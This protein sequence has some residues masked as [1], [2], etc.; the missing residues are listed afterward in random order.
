MQKRGQVTIFVIVGILLLFTII[1]I[2]WLVRIAEQDRLDAQAQEAVDAFIQTTA[3][4]HYITSCLDKVASEGLHVLT[5]QG[6]VIYDYQGGLTSTQTDAG[7]LFEVGYQYYPYRQIFFENGQLVSYTYNISYA[8]RPYV[9]CP[10]FV[11]LPTNLTD[12]A[13]SYYPVAKT[14]FSDYTGRFNSYFFANPPGCGLL[15]RQTT[16]SGFLGKNNLPSLCS[17]DGVNLG[18]GVCH[19]R[20]G[21]DTVAEQNAMERQLERYI[22]TQ[23]P[24]CVNISMYELYSGSNVT[25][26]DAPNITLLFQKPRGVLVQA[27]YPFLVSIQGKEPILK[28]ALFQKTLPVAMNNFFNY[29]FMYIKQ[30][31][32][33]PFFSI[34]ADWHNITKNSFYLPYY[35]VRIH[36]STYECNDS[37]ISYCTDKVLTVTDTSSELLGKPLTFQFAIAQRKPV[38]NYLHD[39]SQSAVINSKQIN[40]QYQIND[41]ISLPVT[42]MDPDGDAIEVNVSGWKETFDDYLDVVA[43]NTEPGGCT[44]EN[45]WAHMRKKPLLAD[46]IRWTESGIFLT[47]S[48]RMEYKTND[49]DLGLH[50]VTIIVT[51]EYGLQDFQIVRILVFDLPKAVLNAYNLFTDINDSFASVEDP[52]VLDGSASSPSILAG[53][54]LTD[55]Q[56]EDLTEDVL[57]VIQESTLQLPVP[58][59]ITIANITHVWFNR[60]RLSSSMPAEE[61][62]ITLIVKQGDIA[63]SNPDTELITVTQCLPHGYTGYDTP[64]ATFSRDDFE[65][66]PY[67][68]SS[69]PDSYAA[70]HVCCEPSLLFSSS[71]ANP[72]QLKGGT[73]APTSVACYEDTFRTTYP[74]FSYS[75]L[76]KAVVDTSDGLVLPATKENYETIF[77]TNAYRAHAY[78]GQTFYHTPDAINFKTNN[79]LN[80]IWQVSYRQSCSGQRGNICGGKLSN[81]WFRTNCP[82]TFSAP[83][84]FARC[85]GPN[86]VGF[87]IQDTLLTCTSYTGTTFEQQV[88]DS[89]SSESGLQE[90]F[91]EVYSPEEFT[92]IM[93]GHCA[94]PTLANLQP[95]G[96]MTVAVS[97]GAFSCMGTCD[98]G[99]CGFTDLTLCSC[100]KDTVC[101]AF[102]ADDFIAVDGTVLAH[103]CLGSGEQAVACTRSCLPSPSTT[104]ASCECRGGTYF[105]GNCCEFGSEAVFIGP[106]QGCFQGAV[107]DPDTIQ[108]TSQGSTLFCGGQFYVCGSSSG[109]TNP[110]VT[111]IT[112]GF[113][114]TL[115]GR[116]CMSVGP[117]WV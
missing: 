44:L 107:F 100:D 61:H 101:D 54:T 21:F 103:R 23:L 99:D 94:G 8:I 57:H 37:T 7:N 91:E 12:E 59:G 33:D 4:N 65:S 110:L 66:L 87:N 115:C 113:G 76:N 82:D 85:H 31:V 28:Q 45:H 93:A 49:T 60:S 90:R 3:L 97:V 41:T 20:F 38:L 13:T 2:T 69:S 79:Q 50:N 95:T 74:F 114:T 108:S 1:I 9:D 15:S 55:Y 98:G 83:N 53:G 104:E 24:T 111:F 52:Y 14:F 70:S 81:T 117:S 84:Q 106:D 51:D 26:I 47:P 72:P 22:Q 19:S 105:G 96:Y 112:P 71:A 75:L 80:D 73:Y 39:S 30:A 77:G 67:P 10:S 102:T 56:F 89:I 58:E 35:D 88:Y 16:W 17:Y 18:K 62:E 27:E 109:Y 36:H 11:Y 86:F 116:T 34:T 40:Y 6:G 43:C 32:S 48:Y 25:I 63:T 46:A 42:P 64:S 68:Y 92:A 78:G 29:V 5:T